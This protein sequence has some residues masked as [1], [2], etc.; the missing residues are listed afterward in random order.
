MCTVPQATILDELL[1]S[2]LDPFFAVRWT[3]RNDHSILRLEP[4]LELV[5]GQIRD[6]SPCYKPTQIHY[7]TSRR[8]FSAGVYAP[9]GET[10]V[11]ARTR[12]L[13]SG[14]TGGHTDSTTR[15]T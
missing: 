1:R 5:F 6:L 9:H 10:D 12:C 3:K 2:Y 7:Q 13:L 11:T 8:N 4:Q 14:V 15:L